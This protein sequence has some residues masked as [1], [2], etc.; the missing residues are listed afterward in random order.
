ME[1]G[2]KYS[3]TNP[4]RGGIYRSASGA[5]VGML[6]PNH[7]PVTDWGVIGLFYEGIT[8]YDG[9]YNQQVTW[10]MESWEFIT[11]TELIMKLKPGVTYHDG[12]DFNA[13]SLKYTFDWIG[14]KKNG[15]WTRGMQR[16][17]KSL[18]V[19]DEY[20]LRWRTHKPWGNFPLGFFAYQ[21]SKKAL[22]GDVALREAEKLGKKVKKAEKKLAK[23]EKK[24]KAAAAGE[25]SEKARAKA[26]KAKRALGK[27][28]KESE[29]A[30][31]RVK[32]H[33]KTDLYPVGT[34]PYMYDEAKPGNYIKAKRNPSW[35]FGK[36]IGRPEMPYFDG[37][38]V[39]VIPDPSIQL[40][41]LRAGKIDVMYISKAQYSMLKGDSNFNV[42]VFPNNQTVGM[43]FNHT[44]PAKDL[45]VRKAVAHAIDRKALIA[46][47][48]FGLAREAS[49]F[50]PGDHWAHN[51]NLKPI[52]FDPELSK[53]LLAEAGY[54]KGLTMRGFSGNS[55]PDST[56]AEAIKAML[57]KVGIDWKVEA[58]DAVS[59]A[60][61]L[62]N[63]EFDV[64]LLITPNIQDPDSISW[65]YLPEG[66]WNYGRV[67]DEEAIPIIKAAK[68]EIDFKKR[69]A[70]YHQIEEIIYKNYDDIWLWWET[71]A[72][73]YRK[74]VQGWNNKMFIENRT[75]YTYSH[76][77]WF[78]EGHP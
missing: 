47:T 77:L 11:P 35:W 76:P 73:A 12:T 42:H 27:L 45:R 69:Q 48:Q 21:L 46:G 36:S 26:E 60:D 13:D 34:G 37:V 19:V 58:V 44:G 28:K 62:R 56:M 64:S 71:S 52:S 38:K 61:R 17:I 5:Y 15:A 53:K 67:K 1:W 65:G 22:M 7:W 59:G 43:I 70:M 49:C 25:A 54:A 9:S 63:L 18:E 55:A 4:V 72:I 75:W 40:A 51:P 41:N 33:I 6:N 2:E 3:P 20:T 14:D 31:A 78:K 24:A 29:E 8:A 68:G 50:Y 66:A 39:T 23:S 74:V 16:D 57:A 30:A 10:L 32:G